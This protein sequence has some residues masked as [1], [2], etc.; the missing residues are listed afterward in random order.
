[1]IKYERYVVF[2]TETTGLKPDECQIIEFAALVLDENAEVIAEIDQFIK[3]DEIPERITELTG[4]TK[5]DTDGGI[6]EG[7]LL[8]LIHGI[9]IKPALWIAHNAQF[10]LSFLRSTYG[11]NDMNFDEEFK[12][13]DFLDTL[14]VYRDRASKPHKLANAIEHYGC[15]DVENSHR[16]IDDVKALW[17]VVKAMT[18]ERND[19]AI[20]TNVFG[21]NTS[22]PIDRVTYK[23]QRHGFKERG[24]RLPEI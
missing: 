9:N 12:N 20:Y 14:T 2:D 3:A 16:A 13:C 7:S 19:L 22:T 21:G 6:T 1:M 10:D 11:R 8:N 17:A 18:K 15:E 24:K 23:Y 5:E 4:I